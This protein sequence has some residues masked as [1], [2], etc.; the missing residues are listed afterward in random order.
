MCIARVVIKEHILP[1]PYVL[2]LLPSNRLLACFVDVLNEI[3]RHIKE[4][5]LD[6]VLLVGVLFLFYLRVLFGICLI[7]LH[8]LLNLFTEFVIIQLCYVLVLHFLWGYSILPSIENMSVQSRLQCP[9][10]KI[11]YDDLSLKAQI[12]RGLL[13]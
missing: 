12:S 11:G 2:V 1:A 13:G 10:V 9:S 6:G 3:Q 7:L 5:V 8:Y 4:V